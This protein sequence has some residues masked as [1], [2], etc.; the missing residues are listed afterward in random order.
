[1]TDTFNLEFPYDGE[2]PRKLVLGDAMLAP[3]EHANLFLTRAKIE[4]EETLRDVTVGVNLTV[5]QQR[6]LAHALLRRIGDPVPVR[7]PRRGDFYRHRRTGTLYHLLLEPARDGMWEAQYRRTSGDFGFCQL[8]P[9][10]DAY[11]PVK[12]EV[13]PAVEAWRVIE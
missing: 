13:T 3:P 6:E 1:M 12:V 8:T 7:E 10:E 4:D 2:T 11:E 9:T 5:E